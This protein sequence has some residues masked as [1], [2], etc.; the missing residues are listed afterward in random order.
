MFD[1]VKDV[2][3]RACKSLHAAEILS[4]EDPDSSASR[5]YYAVFHGVTALFLL[6]KREFTKH[7][8]VEAAV[9]KYL[10]KTAVWSEELGKD[11]SWLSNLRSTG[12]YG[13]TIHVTPD[14]AKIAVEK[15]KKILFEIQRSYPDIFSDLVLG[16][17]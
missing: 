7:S 5:A 17:D 13:G 4:I 12:D 14:E 8:G 1:E 2:W 9:H 10:V 15:A 3:V 6:Q 11:Y 16:E